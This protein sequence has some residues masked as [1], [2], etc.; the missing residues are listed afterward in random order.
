MD[1][2]KFITN[3]HGNTKSE[4]EE[5]ARAEAEEFFDGKVTLD[6]AS[7]SPS[8][9]AGFKYQGTFSFDPGGFHASLRAT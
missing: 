1:S 3:V 7:V 5:A 9:N 8:G 2:Y 4:L 6:H